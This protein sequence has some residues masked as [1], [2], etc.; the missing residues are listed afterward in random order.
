MPEQAKHDPQLLDALAEYFMRQIGQPEPQAP[1]APNPVGLRPLQAAAAAMNPQFAPHFIQQANQPAQAQFNQQ[2]QMFESALQGRREAVA[3]A[4]ALAGRDITGQYS[5]MLPR[6]Q[7]RLQSKEDTITGDEAGKL[8]LDPSRGWKVRRVFNP[9]DG[10]LSGVE[11]MGEAWA[12]PVVTPG[13]FNNQP[14]IGVVSRSGE[15]RGTANVV[16]NAAPVAP[17]EPQTRL[18]QGRATLANIAEV[19]DVWKEFSGKARGPAMFQGALDYGLQKFPGTTRTLVPTQDYNTMSA[20]KSKID[21]VVLR[22][23]NSQSG[24]QYTIQE[25]EKFRQ[26]FPFIF[27]DEATVDNKLANLAQAIKNDIA[28]TEQQFPNAVRKSPADALA[29]ELGLP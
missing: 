4:T 11:V 9:V 25:L 2:Q 18:A 19:K 24:K 5:M 10:T 12:T 15:A 17:V 16:P 7:V 23:V 3:G 22:Y 28:A 29:D 26:F 20:F 27:D 13:T 1:M 8:G 6:N 14:G 21:N